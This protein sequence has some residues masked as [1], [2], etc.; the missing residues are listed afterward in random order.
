MKKYYDV[1]KIEFRNQLIYIPAFLIKNIFFIVIMLIFYTL[2][3]VVY[4]SGGFNGLFTLKQMVWY[5]TFTECIELSK[6]T[7]YWDVQSEVKGGEIAYTIS[8]PYNYNLFQVAKS[9][10]TSLVKLIPLLIMGFIIASVLVGVLPGYF[11]ALPFGIVILVGGIILNTV[12]YLIIGLLSFWVEDAFPFLLLL[13]KVIFIFG[14]LFF[15]IDFLPDWAQGI[16]EVLP[17]TYSAYW[18]AKVMVDFDFSTFFYVVRGQV[19][20]IFALLGVAALIY[21]SA[22][23]RLHVQGG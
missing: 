10:G 4:S 19:F 22:V 12:W 13:Q 18:P 5:L 3:R 17:F 20:W 6:S 15:P 23:R 16:A 9:M 14:G 8:R 2:W 7:I 1:I 21:R 11:K